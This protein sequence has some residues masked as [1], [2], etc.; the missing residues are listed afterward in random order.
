MDDGWRGEMVRL[1]TLL[2]EA[3]NTG[4]LKLQ[5]KVFDGGH[6]RSPISQ[7]L[8]NCKRVDEEGQ[9]V[10]QRCGPLPLGQR[11]RVPQMPR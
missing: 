11:G 8:P 1:M 7:G 3:K 10:N 6:E 4:T 2:R 9:E 5:A